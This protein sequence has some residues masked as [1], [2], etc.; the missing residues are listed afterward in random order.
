MLNV[1]CGPRDITRLHQ[2]FPP[3]LWRE[4]RLDADAA[5]EPDVLAALPEM[6]AVPDA[7]VDAV[8]TS[9]LLEHLYGCEVPQA[10]REFHRVLRPGGVAMIFAPDLQAAAERIAQGRGEEPLY[11]SGLGPVC[12]MDMVYGF[13]PAL[14]AGN[15]LMA[16]RTGFTAAILER[17]LGEAGFI[18]VTVHRLAYCELFATAFQSGSA[19]L[20]HTPVSHRGGV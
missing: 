17:L 10:L 2:Y 13:G 5:V 18:G 1:G 4:V 12:A 8:W 9:H 15:I 16:H 20:F 14:A 6:T 3:P 7:Q 19:G 11:T